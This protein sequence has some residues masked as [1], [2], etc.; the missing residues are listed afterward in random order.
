M[1]SGKDSFKD[2][3]TFEKFVEEVIFPASHFVLLEK[4]H[5][6]QQNSSR[7]VW[8]SVKPDFKFK[9]IASGK[10]FWV[11]VKFRSRYDMEDKL[12]LLTQKQYKRYNSYDSPK[13]P[14]FLLVGAEGY[15]NNPKLISLIP[16]K[17]I[18]HLEIFRSFIY[19]H[20]IPATLCPE[21]ALTNSLTSNQVYGSPNLSD[22]ASGLTY[23]TTHS[24]RTN[25]LPWILGLL[26]VAVF[27]AF[28]FTHSSSAGNPI[29][30]VIVREKV[31]EYYNA[32][33]LNNSEVFDYY[34]HAHLDRWYEH[35]NVTLD[36]VKKN[37]DKYNKKYPYREIEIQWP[38]YKEH[39]LP[40]GDISLSYDVIYNLKSKPTDSYKE[41][42]LSIKSIWS[43]DYKIKSMY[44]VKL[45]R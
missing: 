23:K 32:I 15:P 40:N 22:I 37:S 26:V 4:T 41:F 44:E 38:S 13:C 5:S 28:F 2:G 20:R 27:V 18:R 17:E 19:N 8:S 21:Y 39:V 3:E 7:Y 1:Y 14:V 24:K 36:F 16:I 31:Q 25:F 30:D 33:E 29:N 6:Y 11:E 34:L 35:R 43:A 10:I 9:S 42:Y 12:E 45:N